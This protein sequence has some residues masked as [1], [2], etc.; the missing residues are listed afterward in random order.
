MTRQPISSE[1][2]ARRLPNSLVPGD[3]AFINHD[4]SNVGIF[5]GV[6]FAGH[7]LAAHA[8]ECLAPGAQRV[9]FTNPSDV[10]ADRAFCHLG[11]HP[12]RLGQPMR[13][14]SNQRVIW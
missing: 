6:A 10:E 12:E 3:L 1:E 2:E 8:S 5:H 11:V 9:G 13:T 7:A 4:G 14:G